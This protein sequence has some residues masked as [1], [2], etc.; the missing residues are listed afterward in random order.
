M[1]NASFVTCTY[2]L[3]IALINYPLSR[4][5]A[6]ASYLKDLKVHDVIQLALRVVGEGCIECRGG[7][8]GGRCF[9]I[10][11]YIYRSL[12]FERGRESKLGTNNKSDTDSRDFIL[13]SS[14]ERE[15]KE[16]K[17]RYP[18]QKIFGEL[19]KPTRKL[20]RLVHLR[21]RSATFALILFSLSCNRDK[22]AIL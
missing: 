20:L 2:F 18:V 9:G 16:R 10:Y 5:T 7:F 3:L 17:E 19:K 12:L 6:V 14:S 13:S 15:K 22:H 4:P 8:L 21:K 11:I 1:Y